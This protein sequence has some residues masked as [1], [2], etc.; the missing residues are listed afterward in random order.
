MSM[1]AFLNNR[2]FDLPASEH[3]INGTVLYILCDDTFLILNQLMRSIP[4]N[5]SN[6]IFHLWYKVLFYVSTRSI[7]DG[8]L[9]YF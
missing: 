3:H 6:T 8:Y 9:G 1:F 4:M 2:C 7:S 5:A